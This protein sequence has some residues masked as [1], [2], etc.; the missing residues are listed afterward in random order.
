MPLAFLFGRTSAEVP[1]CYFICTEPDTLTV[2]V[3]VP[4]SIG[5][6][7]AILASAPIA[8]A[9]IIMTGRG[10]EPLCP[11]LTSRIE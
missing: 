3:D 6:G 2:T 9:L 4:P 7:A 5:T 8:R 11:T 1:A 10:I